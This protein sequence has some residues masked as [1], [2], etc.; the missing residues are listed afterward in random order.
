MSDASNGAPKERLTIKIPARVQKNVEYKAKL[1][2]WK[3][4]EDMDDVASPTKTRERGK[5]GRPISSQDETPGSVGTREVLTIKIPSAQKRKEFLVLALRHH[6][7]L[8][9]QQSRERI[10]H[11]DD[12]ASLPK[13]KKRVRQD[14]DED[15]GSVTTGAL[16][17]KRPKLEETYKVHD[18]CSDVE[19]L[20]TEQGPRTLGNDARGKISKGTE[21]GNYHVQDHDGLSVGDQ[22]NHKQ[23]IGTVFTEAEEPSGSEEIN[24]QGYDQAGLPLGSQEDVSKG[25]ESKG[26]E[27]DHDHDH[28]GLTIGDQNWEDPSDG[29][30]QDSNEANKWS[31]FKAVFDY[32]L[33][34]YRDFELS[35]HWN[36]CEEPGP[37][38]RV[39]PDHVHPMSDNL[40]S[41]ELS[42]PPPATAAGTSTTIT[43]QF[44]IQT[45]DS[46]DLDL[47]AN[48][49]NLPPA[50]DTPQHDAVFK[51]DD[52][53]E[54]D[55]L[56]RRWLHDFL[57]WREE[58]IVEPHVE[59]HVEPRGATVQDNN[60]E[61]DIIDVVE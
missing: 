37:S 44:D 13:T 9:G 5:Q 25:K 34:N 43:T 21:M 39:S 23:P 45:S 42:V 50:D 24:Y 46:N 3:N 40:Q 35:H 29:Q 27:R 36:K 61:E 10:E 11:T 2:S 33:Q 22:G 30:E 41:G 38:G 26:K 32:C 7:K 57:D 8:A 31:E 54:W 12:V 48:F 14:Q 16:K 18:H 1:R 28:D 17:A 51:F 20:D 52:S 49:A 19:L 53:E 58:A 15:I 4:Y 47:G 6:D 56:A 60:V 55:A 59:P